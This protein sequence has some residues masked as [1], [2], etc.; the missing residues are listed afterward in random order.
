MVIIMV[1][2]GGGVGI[3]KHT[4]TAVLQL[5][6]PSA[7]RDLVESKVA[8]KKALSAGRSAAAKPC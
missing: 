2:T 3:N 7:L 4:I 8:S 5:P 6:L 1:H